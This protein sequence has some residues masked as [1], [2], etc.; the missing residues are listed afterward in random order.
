MKTTRIFTKPKVKGMTQHL[1]CETHH[2]V[3]GSKPTRNQILLLCSNLL[4][5]Q[6]HSVDIIF[7]ACMWAFIFYS[8]TVNHVSSTS[9]LSKCHQHIHENFISFTKTHFIFHL[10]RLSTYSITLI[11]RTREIIVDT[12]VLSEQLFNSHLERQVGC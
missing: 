6:R 10:Q 12:V 4:L 5:K 2:Y 9:H 1:E 7:L 8:S 3:P 11:Q